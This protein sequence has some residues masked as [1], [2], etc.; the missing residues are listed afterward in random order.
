MNTSRALLTG[1]AHGAG[2]RRTD[3][4]AIGAINW[5]VTGMN[6]LKIIRVGALVRGVLIT[7]V[8]GMVLGA[9]LGG[10]VG[11]ALARVA[12]VAQTAEGAVHVARAQL[13]AEME[14]AC[15][16]WF[17]DKKAREMAVGRIIT[18]K[19]PAFLSRMNNPI[20]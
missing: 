15:V 8:L 6:D 3:T 13:N 20:D 4:G 2:T 9:A 19:A 17:T 7:F 16:N 14:Q 5:K 12:A 18:C 10:F 1:T 11:A